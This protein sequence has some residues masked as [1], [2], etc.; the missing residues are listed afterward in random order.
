MMTYNSK[1]LLTDIKQISTHQ[2]SN[3]IKPYLTYYSNTVFVTLDSQSLN[4][5]RKTPNGEYLLKERVIQNLPSK[6]KMFVANVFEIN[7]IAQAEEKLK[8]LQEKSQIPSFAT[9]GQ[10]KAE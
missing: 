4:Y 7:N 6:P 2:N 1:P 9:E 3:Q 5:D 8:Y 10:T